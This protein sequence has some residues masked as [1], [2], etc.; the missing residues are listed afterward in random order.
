MS[1]QAAQQAQ[2]QLQNPELQLEGVGRCMHQD[3]F[4]PFFVSRSTC[5]QIPACVTVLY[6]GSP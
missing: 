6:F 2:L 5:D 1:L 3:T 4:L